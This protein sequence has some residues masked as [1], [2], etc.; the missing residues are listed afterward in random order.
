MEMGRVLRL[1][2]SHGRPGRAVILVQ[3]H[4]LVVD[5][6]ER[7]GSRTL[8]LD[9]TVRPNPR[10]VMIGGFAA[11]IFVLERHTNILDIDI[12]RSLCELAT[13]CRYYMARLALPMY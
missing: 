9:L 1:E 7:G 3:S 5:A 8:R 10:P 4:R 2:R 12:D 6:L 11:W 13:H